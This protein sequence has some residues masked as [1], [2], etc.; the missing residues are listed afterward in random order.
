MPTVRNARGADLFAASEDERTIHPIQVKA[1]SGTPQDTRLGLS[2][3]KL[4]TPW[5]V[6]VV[7]ARTPQIACYVISLEEILAHKMRDPGTRSE[8]PEEERLFWFHRKFYTPGGQFE[9][10][11]ALNGWHR[12]GMPRRSS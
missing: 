12:L 5:W 1:H 4:V 3:E 7:F 11:D 9:M 2:P 10:K 6:F 8:K